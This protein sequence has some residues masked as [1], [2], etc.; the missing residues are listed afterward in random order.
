MCGAT[1]RKDKY[2]NIEEVFEENKKKFAW[3]SLDFTPF[4]GQK[5]IYEEDEDE[6]F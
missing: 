2:A 3:T 5:S 1:T 6:F 4:W